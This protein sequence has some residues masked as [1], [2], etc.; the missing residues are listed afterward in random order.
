MSKTNRHPTQIAYLAAVAAHASAVKAC[1]AEC[2]AKGYI[3]VKGED[4]ST[5]AFTTVCDGIDAANLAH[6][7][8]NLWNARRIA[9]YEVAEWFVKLSI[10]G[11]PDEAVRLTALL[12]K[13]RT[14]S[15]VR[16]REVIDL[17]MTMPYVTIG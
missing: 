1:E 14:L 12:P 3:H 10:V 6:D 7:V 9:G 4:Q 16:L 5:A 15:I 11:R 2:A 17:A 8:W 13:V